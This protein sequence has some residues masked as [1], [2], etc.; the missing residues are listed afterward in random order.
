MGEIKGPFIVHSWG[1]SSP[2]YVLNH[3]TL[4]WIEVALSMHLGW[5][6]NPWWAAVKLWRIIAKYR[7]K[8]EYVY[9]IEGWKLQFWG[10]IGWLEKLAQLNICEVWRDPH[11]YLKKLTFSSL[12]ATSKFWYQ[13]LAHLSQRLTRWAYRMGLKLASLLLC[14]SASVRPS[15]HTFKHEYL[16]NQCADRNQILTE[17]SLGWG[18]GCIRFWARSDWNSG[19]HGNR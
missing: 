5:T 17:A 10:C 4:S 9:R 13:F 15:V 16:R 11:L 18:K 8:S 12:N 19:F 7:L 3:V 2:Q 1:Y 14:V 6:N